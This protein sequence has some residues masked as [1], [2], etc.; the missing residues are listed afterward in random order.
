MSDV[1]KLIKAV[2]E[3]INTVIDIIDYYPKKAEYELKKCAYAV[4]VEWYSKYNPKRY[5]RQGDL[6]H[7]FKIYKNKDG[8]LWSVEFGPEFMEYT[9]HQENDFI[10][11]NS[12]IQGYHGGSISEDAG[13]D[14]PRWRTPV[15]YYKYWYSEAPQSFSPYEKIIDEMQSVSDSL[16]KEIQAKI[17]KAIK[18]IRDN[19]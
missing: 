9:H 19:K 15:P 13:I 11:E 6:L 17:E 14:I 12:F 1:D 18:K 3:A 7:T 16:D 5:V 4:I 2:D 8:E 10:Y